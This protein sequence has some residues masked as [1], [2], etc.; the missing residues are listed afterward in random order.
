MTDIVKEIERE[1]IEKGIQQE[2]HKVAEKMFR[3]GA[4]IS[5]VM[6]ITGLTETETNEIRRQLY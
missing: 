3:K 5:D 2:R 1:A 4:S 6:E